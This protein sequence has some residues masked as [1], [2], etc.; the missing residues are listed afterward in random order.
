VRVT[1]QK[2]FESCGY[3][4]LLAF[5]SPQRIGEISALLEDQPE[6]RRIEMWV[7]QDAKVRV[8]GTSGAGSSKDVKLRGFPADTEFYEPVVTAG[9]NL[10]TAEEFADQRYLMLHETIAKEM[11]LGVGDEIEID[12]GG[13]RKAIWT[14]AGLIQDLTPRG[15]TAY[16]ERGVLTLELNEVDR[17]S[18]AEIKLELEEA[19]LDQHLEAIKNLEDYLKSEGIE[20]SSTLSSIQEQ[21]QFAAQLNI[22]ITVLLIMTVLVALVGGVGLSGTLSINVVERIREIGVMRAV[23]ASSQDLALIFIGEGLLIGLLS[24]AIAL[25]ISLVGGIALVSVLAGVI[26]VSVNFYYSFIGIFIW[27][28]VVAVLSLLAS[29]LPALHATRISVATSL[30]YE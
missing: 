3:D 10:L 11:N 22:L 30:A 24:W 9:K 8:P 6:V 28:L 17:A 2:A 18:V 29:W 23:G 7:W 14:I 13:G 4:V 27:L 12:L 26:G 25:P 5:K 21:E 16:V 20:L 1:I 15:N 19:S